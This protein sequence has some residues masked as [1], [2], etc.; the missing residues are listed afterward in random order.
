MRPLRENISDKSLELMGIPKKYTHATIEDFGTYDSDSLARVKNF[1]KDYIENIE[2]NVSHSRG[3]FFF[4]SNG[5][6]KSFLSSIILKEAYRHRYTCRR[7][8]FSVYVN[9]YADT[10]KDP[11]NDSY[12]Q[13]K[14]AEFLVLEEIGKEIDSK[15]AT[16]ILEDLL[17]YRDERG[18]TTIICSNIPLDEIKKH[19]GSSV[20]SVITGC[21]TPIKINA[22]DKRKETFN[23]L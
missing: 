4:G 8:T 14:S 5:V 23:E 22:V 13:S 10:W 17:R 9:Q 20:A 18:Y 12:D 3:I 6:G 2:Y 19:Y 16:P 15:I 1:C 21:M 7:I 11:E